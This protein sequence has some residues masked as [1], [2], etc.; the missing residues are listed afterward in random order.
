MSLIAK[1]FGITATG[2]VMPR[3]TD[4]I[5]D[6]TENYQAINDANP[7]TAGDPIDTS[8]DSTYGQEI[9][10]QAK[11]LMDLWEGFQTA[12]NSQYPQTA[13]GA[14]LS[15]A[16]QFTGITR[17]QAT[18]STALIAF[19]GVDGTAI[20]TGT[21]VASSVDGETFQTT[22]ASG[23]TLGVSATAIYLQVAAV[24]AG[25]TFNIT[26]N[27]RTP[28][29]SY[30]IPA[31]SITA[32][33]S[34]LQTWLA[35]QSIAFGG[36]TFTVVTGASGL[37][38]TVMITSNTG[39][40]ITETGM[41]PPS[42]I[43]GGNGTI[44]N[45]G[46][47]FPAQALNY[48]AIDEA[49]CTLT[50]IVSPQSGLTAA[51]NYAEAVVGQA[52][53]T[54]AALL[55]RQQNSLAVSGGGNTDAIQARLINDVPGVTYATVQLNDT[56]G[57]VNGLPPHS[58]L[59]VVTGGDPQA[60]AQ[61]IWEAK[62]A[63]ITAYS[64]AG[65]NSSTAPFGTGSAYSDT[66]ASNFL[67][68]VTDV[69]GNS[70][71]IG[72]ARPTAVPIYVA[73]QVTPTTSLGAAPSSAVITSLITAAVLAYGESL[74][75]GEDVVAGRFFAPIYAECAGLG[76]LV[77]YIKTSAGPTSA[78]TISI[79]G[80]NQATFSAANISVTVESAVS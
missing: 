53:E 65:Y 35:G 26:L 62:S 70:Q 68:T 34:A 21:I 51:N 44:I 75:P 46:T 6:L 45:I 30:T 60:I 3:L 67:G 2:F 41:A 23:D 24:G 27:G 56:D 37:A 66:G 13:S 72:F 7:V 80:A 36:F 12:Y 55:L 5:T 28:S 52:V 9:G 4:I 18:Q 76:L 57:V 31:L 49:A 19:F 43:T 20:S 11:A 47:E 17:L 39:A 32:L 22:D 54:D 74:Q 48:G 77:V 14:S 69:S 79:S 8:P 33:V 61:E 10:V 40:I 78:A 1:G 16:V 42:G 59:C 58:I 64:G 15:N 71:T 29:S 50:V 73:I 38:D 25:D 63:G